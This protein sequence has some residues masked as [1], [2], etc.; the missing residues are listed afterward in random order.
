MLLK[1]LL[2]IFQN[3]NVKIMLLL[4][5]DLFVILLILFALLLMDEK[6]IGFVYAN[7]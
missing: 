3:N 5:K 1:I 2:N 6:E 7:F 4:G